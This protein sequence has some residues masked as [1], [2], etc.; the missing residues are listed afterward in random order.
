MNQALRWI[1]GLWIA[2]NLSDF[3]VT[4]R[5]WLFRQVRA[6][7]RVIVAK[8]RQLLLVVLTAVVLVRAVRS[9]EAKQIV[10]ALMLA[11][12]VSLALAPKP[13]PAVGHHQAV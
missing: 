12:V 4:V 8:G 7:G 9:G 5:K 2:A 10:L 1:V 13:L 11:F 3:A 6:L